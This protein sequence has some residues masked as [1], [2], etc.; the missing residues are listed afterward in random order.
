ML[1][2][3]ERLKSKILDNLKKE[4]KSNRLNVKLAIIMIGDND[5]SKIYVKNK[6]N[7]CKEIGIEV[8][9]YLLSPKRM[10]P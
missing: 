3:G 10:I 8:D 4:I 1:L 6:I 2:D 5:A 7:S 9:E